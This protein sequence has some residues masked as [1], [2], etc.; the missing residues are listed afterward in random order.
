MLILHNIQLRYGPIV[1]IYN[2]NNYLNSNKF[3]TVQF[4]SFSGTCNNILTVEKNIYLSFFSLQ[5]A[6]HYL[7]VTGFELSRHQTRIIYFSS[8]I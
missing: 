3:I 8:L 2:K 1:G 7:L 4:N 5:I 6:I